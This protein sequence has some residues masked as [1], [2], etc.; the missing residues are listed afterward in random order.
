MAEAISGVPQSCVIG[1]I[2]FVIY[3]NDLP[4]RLSVDSKLYA[5]DIKLIAPRNCH[6]I[7]QNFLN[8]SASWPKN[9]ELDLNPTKS[10]HLPVD[11]SPH[12]VTY[13]LPSHSPPNTQNISTVSTA[14]DLVIV[15]NIRLNAEDNVVS[16]ANKGRRMLFYLKRSF[17]ALTPSIFFP[18][19][20]PLSGHILNMQY[21]RPPPFSP[22]IAGR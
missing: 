14:E 9:W 10:E 18:C 17:T 13:T 15:L 7:L 11:N 4:D 19:I 8:I 5:N 1:P 12:F 16:A 21:K 22:G 6:N 20:K 3:V 2:L